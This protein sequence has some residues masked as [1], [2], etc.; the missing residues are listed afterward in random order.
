MF[1]G[2]YTKWRERRINCVF[3]YINPSFFLNKSV[4]EF[5]CGYGDIG[6]YFSQVKSNVSSV[7]IRED[8]L[9]MTKYKYPHLNV[10]KFDAEKDELNIN[11][12]IAIHFGTLN[13]IDNIERHLNDVCKKCNYIILDLE[14]ADSLYDEYIKKNIYESGYDQSFYNNGSKPSANYIENILTKNNFKFKIIK[15]PILD[16]NE[17]LYSW[18]IKNT[19]SYFSGKSRFWICWNNNYECPIYSNYIENVSIVLQGKICND[20]DIY[21][22]LSHYISYGQVILSIYKDLTDINVINRI[23]QYFPSVHIVNNNIIQ[24]EIDLKSIGKFSGIPYHDNCYHQIC[25]TLKGLDKVI[26]KYVIK[27][28]TDHYYASLN[29]F[30]KFMIDQNKIITSSVYVRGVDWTRYHLSDMLFGHYTNEIKLL[31]NLALTNYYPGCPEIVIW[32]PFL[33]YKAS[34]DNINLDELD[35]NSYA[36]WMAKNCYVYCINI[37]YK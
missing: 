15:D 21:H 26:S 16:S 36:E 6:N 37:H 2:H 1:D 31:F 10:Y 12:D 28:R 11:Y 32:K 4:I 5:G 23:C 34:L 29:N 13:H 19:E 20:I 24:N 22:T 27:S 25:T 18:K 14:I 9:E 17:H 8:F 7:D 30:I 3:K 33:F 35:N